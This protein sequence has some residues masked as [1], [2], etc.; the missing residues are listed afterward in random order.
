MEGVTG[1]DVVRVICQATEQ[2]GVG[3]VCLGTSEAGAPRLVGGSARG[4]P[5]WFSGSPAPL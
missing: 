1:D 2:E 3:P 4:F 5:A